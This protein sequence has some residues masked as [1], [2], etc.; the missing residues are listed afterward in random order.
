MQWIYPIQPFR[1][2]SLDINPQP[3]APVLLAMEDQKSFLSL[4]SDL[5]F[6]KLSVIPLS[7]LK[8]SANYFQPLYL[9]ALSLECLKN[10]GM[11]IGKP[12]KD[13]G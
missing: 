12:K 6:C 1:P 9:L 8:I 3:L 5:F 2:P 10:L 7:E 4:I 13:L 11:V